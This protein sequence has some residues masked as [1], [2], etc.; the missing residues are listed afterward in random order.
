M[1]LIKKLTKRDLK[2]NKKR[3]IMII[4]GIALATFLVTGVV[5]LVSSFNVSILEYTKKEFGDYHYEF[6]DVPTKEINEIKENE[7]VESV[8]FTKNMGNYVLDNTKG[9]ANL[10]LLSFSK[11]AM[12][13]LGIELIN[14]RMP[15]N[16]NEIVISNKMEEY[17]NIKLELG[18]K[19]DLTLKNEENEKIETYEIVGIIDIT[20][21]NIEPKFISYD[22]EDMYYTAITYLTDYKEN[23]YLNVYTK[24]KNLETRNET[25]AK[26]LGID[27]QKFN[28][29]KSNNKVITEENI[30]ANDS[31]K[32]KYNAN[33]NL[34]ELQ[35]GDYIDETKTMLY[36]VATVIII[37]II[38]TSVYCIKNSFNIAITEKIK[39]YGMLISIGATS[40]QIK[41]SVLYEAFILATI[42]IPI[43]IVLGTG[44]IF[45]LMNIIKNILKENLSGM[46]YIF[47]T[48]INVIVITI[49]IS[50]LI[51]YLSA[52]KSAKIVSKISPIE[53]IKNSENIKLKAKNLKSPKYIKKIF[54]IGGDIAYKSIKRDKKKY[55]TIKVSIVVSVATFIAIIAFGNYAFK[56]NNMYYGDYKYNIYLLGDYEGLKKISED[57][58]I[59]EYSFTRSSWIIVKNSNKHFSNTNI[60]MKYMRSDDEQMNI[61]SLGEGEYKRYVN[62]LGLNYDD[63]KNKAILMDYKN[64]LVN[65]DGKRMHRIFRIYDYQKGDILNCVREN[66]EFNLE[67]AAVT[68]QKPMELIDSTSAYVIIS[69][70]YM[71]KFQEKFGKM[72]CNLYINSENDQEL[73]KYIAEKYA[74][75]YSYMGNI[76]REK[77]EEKSMWITILI[78]LYIFII[79]ILFIGLTNIFNT[80]TTSMELRQKEFA[81]LKA[82]GM[83]KKEF[84]R[85]IGLESLFWRRKNINYW[86]YFGNNYFIYNI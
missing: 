66:E 72:F 5:T 43:G 8:F 58:N 57:A 34:I 16:K 19:I 65:V 22:V 74:D 49:L 26:I 61:I 53:A 55:R 75:S 78:F 23:D 86:Y 84:N 44:T 41:R 27:I 80:I 60:D 83:T 9:K 15:E 45:I 25:T 32:Y 46:Q 69:D 73:E 40:K 28:Q 18:E 3:T 67:I 71:D 79:V 62:K 1:K 37:I 70:E 6:I 42:G 81:H 76:N 24:Y 33:K 77:S 11:E 29:L 50:S 35:T 82:I 59:K 38:I 30:Y 21:E 52:R 56:A 13:K 7:N 14:G 51:I 31:N 64:E 2:L 20:D 39:Y 68:E 17:G 10:N 85:M 4:L 54:G 47:S 36:S 48:N 12:E 63:V